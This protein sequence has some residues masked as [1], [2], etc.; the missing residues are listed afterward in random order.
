MSYEIY[1]V[2]QPVLSKKSKIDQDR[3][4]EYIRSHCVC[5]NVNFYSR[6]FF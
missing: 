1:L 4:I 3:M 5:F 2:L 6:L